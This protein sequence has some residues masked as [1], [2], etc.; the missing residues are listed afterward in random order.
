MI[1]HDDGCRGCITARNHARH[2]GGFVFSDLACCSRCGPTHSSSSYLHSVERKRYCGR[3]ADVMAQARNERF[4]VA[5]MYGI[6]IDADRT[7][8]LN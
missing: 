1:E 8:I 4:Y 2:G 6:G 3:C 7:L 5:V